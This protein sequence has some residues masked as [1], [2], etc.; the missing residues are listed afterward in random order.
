VVENLP[1]VNVC[2]GRD[3][4]GRFHRPI[5]SGTPSESSSLAAL[6]TAK[7]CGICFTRFAAVWLAEPAD[8]RKTATGSNY[9]KKV[10]LYLICFIALVWVCWFPTGVQ[11]Q[12]VQPSG[13]TNAD[14]WS[15]H[16]MNQPPPSQ[17]RYNVSQD[18][19]DEIRQLYLQAKQEAEKKSAIKD[20]EKK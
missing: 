3:A 8:R 16:Q 1:Q 14:Q 11:A 17:D 6:N 20:N 10:F 5:F 13:G 7:F 12:T 19:L 18:R 4:I 2:D 9:M 15:S